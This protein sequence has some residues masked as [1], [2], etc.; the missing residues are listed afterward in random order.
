MA[1][2]KRVMDQNKFRNKAERVSEKVLGDSV[3]MFFETNKPDDAF[4]DDGA[5]FVTKY[6]L[7]AVFGIGQDTPGRDANNRMREILADLGM[8][9]FISDRV[10]VEVEC[11]ACDGEGTETCDLGC[12]HP[13]PDCDGSGLVDPLDSEAA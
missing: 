12:D 5:L 4:E 3:S 11:E 13:C 2:L 6:G 10:L 8:K 9:R 1:G 7:Q